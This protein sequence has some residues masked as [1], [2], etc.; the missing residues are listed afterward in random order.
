M[1]FFQHP[2]LSGQQETQAEPLTGLSWSAPFIFWGGL[3]VLM[4]LV[5]LWLIKRK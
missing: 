5:L 1:L 3:L 4:F 2:V